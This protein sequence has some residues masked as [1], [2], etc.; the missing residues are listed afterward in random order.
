MPFAMMS[1]LN[2]LR[3]TSAA[4]VIATTFVTLAGVQTLERSRAD[5]A[6]ELSVIW[7]GADGSQ[8]KRIELGIGKSLI[9]ELPRDAKEVFVANPKV[10]NAVVRSPRKIFIIGVADGA[11][12]VFALDHEG[13]QIANT[14]IVIGRDMNVLRRLL[15]TAM[16]NS[17][18]NVVPVG[19]SIVLNGSVAFSGRSRPGAGYRQRLYRHIGDR[20]K[21]RNNRR[22]RRNIDQPRRWNRSR[23]QGH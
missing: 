1:I 13:R 23:R 17:Q 9:L 5:V 16:P 10:A 8:A 21:H 20:R 15:K 6:T 14:D 4:L 3:R 19:D 12:S 18:I 2:P 7:P 11:T 22:R